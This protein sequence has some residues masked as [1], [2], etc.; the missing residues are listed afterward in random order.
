[1]LV[2]AIVF[3]IITSLG[4]MV[5]IGGFPVPAGMLMMLGL[6]IVFGGI[7]ILMGMMMTQL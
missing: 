1:M 7:S 3:R 5:D 2:L 6:L 4:S